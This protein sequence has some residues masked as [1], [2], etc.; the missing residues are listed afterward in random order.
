MVIVVIV[1]GIRLMPETGVTRVDDSKPGRWDIPARIVI[2]TGFILLITGSASLLGARLT[3]LLAT[4][5][6][7]TII[8]TVFAHRSQG[9]AGAVSLLRGL[10]F[11]LFGFASFFLALGVLLEYTNVQWAFVLAALSALLVHGISLLILRQKNTG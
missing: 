7:Y 4:I 10:M 3:G 1:I 5:P 2:G 8:L 11:G 6:L 9:F